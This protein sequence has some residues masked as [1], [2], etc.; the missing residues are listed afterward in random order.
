MTGKVVHVHHH[1]DNGCCCC[2]IG[3]AIGYL[4]WGNPAH[5]AEI[6]K[7]ENKGIEKTVQTTPT[8]QETTQ[9]EKGFLVKQIEYYQQNISPRIKQD[10]GVEELC[11]YTPSCSA[12]AKQAVEKYGNIKGS[13]LAVSRLL[14]C[15]PLSKGGYDPVK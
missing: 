1:D 4:L 8:T 12:Y 3:L 11:K 13:R 15:N 5:G 14:R 7:T 6:K 10:L 2:C 9:V